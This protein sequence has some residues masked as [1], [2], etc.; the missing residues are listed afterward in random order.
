MEQ[1][2]IKLVLTL[3]GFDRLNPVQEEALKKGLLNDKNFLIASPTASGKTLIAE[4]A[5]L[6][7]ILE[8]K[9]KV[10]YMVPLVALASEKYNSFKEKYEKMKIKVAL[11]VGDFDSSDPWLEEYD[12][13]VCSNEKMDS[14]IRHG[15]RWIDEV[16]LI[17]CDEIHLIG[18]ESRGSTLEVTLTKLRELT[19]ARI[20]ALSATIKNYEELAKWLDATY[21]TSDWRPVELY[22]GICFE[23]K[24][25]FPD[26]K[27]YELGEKA[28][29]KD[30]VKNT[31]EMNK[32]C[33]IFV[34]MRKAAEKLAEDLR[35]ITNKFLSKEEK[36]ILS[37]LAKNLENV[38][39]KPTEQCKR[40]A[41][42]IASGVAFHHAGLLASQKFMIEEGFRK[43]IIKVIVAT[44]TLAMGVSLPAFRVI[45]RDVKRYYPKY[46]YI[47]IPVLEYKQ[48]SG[49]AGR[50][51]YDKWGEAILIA[52]TLSEARRLY[53]RYVLGE[54]EEIY[55][56]LSIEPILRT[57]VLSLIASA[58]YTTKD[59]L[60]R[61]FSKTFYASQ[62]GDISS[63]MKKVKKII[64]MLIRWKFLKKR[65]DKIV[66]TRL[67]KRVSELYI[68]PLTAYK[69]V[70]FLIKIKN[71]ENA[72][73]FS[74]LFLISN[75]NEMQPLPNVRSR[76]YEDIMER[77]EL[78]TFLERVPEEWEDEFE[79]FI[80]SV[81]LSLAFEDWINEKTEAYILEK[82]S[83][84]PGEF[85]GRLEIADWLLYSTK[86]LASIMHLNKR[87]TELKKLR[88]RMRYGVKEELIPLV[89]L[90]G[91][92][93]IKARRLFNAGIKK[94]SDIKTANF[95]RLKELV[96]EATAKQIKS[97]VEEDKNENNY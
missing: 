59:D 35:D 7:T 47:Y 66:A 25:E 31:M 15:I 1:D 29:E 34:S 10:I 36:E 68:D 74:Y 91:I 41:R 8:K 89:R 97:L 26:W 32:Q 21:I 43:G 20:I 83:I 37:K 93:K 72:K 44:P 39:E 28:N 38:L 18:D 77:V 95:E 53:E 6:K 67:G 78:E 24:I 23:N 55:S 94:V 88:V 3:S 13:I 64:K 16:G 14:L 69:I 4:I 84:T 85:R 70:D 11:S 86:E 75:S 87:E 54:M 45:I 62:Y 76:E 49:R 27:S 40:L 33:I 73:E 52:K 63:I 81:K 51:E 22:E 48:M 12:I 90:R 50:P 5:M 82:Y 57:H 61:F 92:G 58:L 46:G 96:G 56:K 42:C 30:I 60:E 80:R 65:E 79:D 17:I 71:I 19:N 9:K 2:I